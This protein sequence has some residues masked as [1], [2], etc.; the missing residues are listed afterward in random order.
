[1]NILLKKSC[2]LN[3]HD[4]LEEKEVMNMNKPNLVGLLC[5]EKRR[6]SILLLS[7]DS[8]FSTSKDI[9]ISFGNSNVYWKAKTQAFTSLVNYQCFS[10]EGSA[11]VKQYAV[12]SG[13]R[14]QYCP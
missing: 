8:I 4:G 11:Y 5:K 6:H 3:I 10:A 1:M 9:H 2:L 7:F 14:A 13:K 12:F